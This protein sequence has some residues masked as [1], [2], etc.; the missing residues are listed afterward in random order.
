MALVTVMVAPE[1]V[2]L[3]VQVPKALAT[4]VLAALKAL[5]VPV[6]LTMD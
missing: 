2:V 4:L 6:E 3:V 1:A 5:A